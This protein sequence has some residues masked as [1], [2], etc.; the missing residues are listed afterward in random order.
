MLQ[1]SAWRASSTNS[2]V[3]STRATLAGRRSV[4]TVTCLPGALSSSETTNPRI[5]SR[6]RNSFPSRA[7]L[8]VVGE[9]GR[10]LIRLAAIE[11]VHVA[12]EQVAYCKL[13]GRHDPCLHGRSSR[14]LSR[15]APRRARRIGSAASATPSRGGKCDLSPRNHAAH[16]G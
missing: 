4:L 11:Q 1:E 10:E 16:R 9:Q 5:G 8:G 12:R 2:L 15:A 13:V 3:A 7:Q 6:P 14:A